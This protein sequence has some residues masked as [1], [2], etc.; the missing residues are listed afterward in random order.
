MSV[1]CPIKFIPLTDAERRPLDFA[2]M[3][4]VFAAHNELGRLCDEDI[5]KND[6]KARLNSAGLVAHTEVPITVAWRGF[7][8]TYFLDLVVADALLYEL[9]VAAAL[10]GHHQAQLLNYILLLDLPSGKLL[11]FRP[12]KVESEFVATRLTLEKRRAI[13]FDISRWQPVSDH[14]P[15][16]RE[17]A[18]DL[19]RTLGAF[20]DLDLYAEALAWSCVN[21]IPA[22]IPL[23]RDGLALGM[24]EVRLIAPGVAFQLTAHTENLDRIESHLRRFLRHTSLRALQWLNF[25]HATITLTT[26][27]PTA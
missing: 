20:L 3:S 26:L 8:K 24:Q 6:L 22:R 1:T 9:K 21:P 4:H 10:T 17:S 13:A 19:I 27:L 12:A 25:N 7:R 14:C 15:A 18:E 23:T 11:N 16:F 2:V 5:Y